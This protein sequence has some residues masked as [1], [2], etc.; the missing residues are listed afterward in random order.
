MTNEQL[1]KHMRILVD[2]LNRR[3]QSK[4]VSAMAGICQD[5]FAVSSA[6]QQALIDNNCLP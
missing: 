1:K 5:L 2:E 4:D 3:Q 6:V